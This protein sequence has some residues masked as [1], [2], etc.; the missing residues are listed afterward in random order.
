MGEVREGSVGDSPDLSHVVSALRLNR[1]S[2]V[3]QAAL[4]A[5]HRR[6][7]Q[8]PGDLVE[9]RW[10]G[11][12]TVVLDYMERLRPLAINDARFAEDC[13]CG[14]GVDSA[15]LDPKTLELVRWQR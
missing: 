14:A 9:R 6:A 3:P 12:M 11:R 4:V 2:R 10:R 15:E 7:S 8:R 5:G 1:L 13:L